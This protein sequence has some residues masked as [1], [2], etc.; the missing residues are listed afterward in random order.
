[1]SKAPRAEEASVGGK[2]DN[3]NQLPASFE[4]PAY[5]GGGGGS[6]GHDAIGHSHEA[7]YRGV[8]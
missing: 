6:P 7:S 1:M 4:L 3:T 8:T 2:D 5:R